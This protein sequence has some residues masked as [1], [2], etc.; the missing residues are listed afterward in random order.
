MSNLS[1]IGNSFVIAKLAYDMAKEAY[2]LARQEVLETGVAEIECD[3]GV[4]VKVSLQERKNFDNKK[5]KS[6]LTPEQIAECEMA[7]TVSSVV[8]VKITAQ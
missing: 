7:P 8:T 2:D 4:L 3:N 6:F 1:P 5:A